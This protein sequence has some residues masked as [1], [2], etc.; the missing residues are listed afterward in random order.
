[1]I[2]SELWVGNGCGYVRWIEDPLNDPAK[3][4][5]EHVQKQVATKFIEHESEISRLG[6]EVENEDEDANE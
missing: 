6:D 1:M 2:F 3:I 4:V 5:I